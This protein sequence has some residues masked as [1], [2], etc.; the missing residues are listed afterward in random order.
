MRQIL[1]N[2]FFFLFKNFL[3]FSLILE[4]K[5]EIPAIMAI[6]ACNIMLPVPGSIYAYEPEIL[7][8]YKLIEKNK[9]FITLKKYHKSF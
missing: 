8:K 5:T 6:N 2:Y 4:K 3:I 9:I 1:N 7:N